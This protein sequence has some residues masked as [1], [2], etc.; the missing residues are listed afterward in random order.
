[1]IYS[2]IVIVVNDKNVRSPFLRIKRLLP[3]MRQL[4]WDI[5]A[6]ESSREK[7]SRTNF[8][9]TQVGWTVGHST[10]RDDDSIFNNVTRQNKH[11]TNSRNKECSGM[12]DWQN[13][14]Q[15]IFWS[16]DGQGK[17][18]VIDIILLPNKYLEIL[19]VYKIYL[20]N[21]IWTDAAYNKHFPFR[22]LCS[23][24]R[25]AEK[26]PHSK[27]YIWTMKVTHWP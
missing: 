6:T 8:F 12:L 9:V 24:N 23:F 20:Q 25:P 15:G 18:I 1:M 10:E 3:S 5:Y 22:Y 14:N 4:Q 16:P 2:Y 21:Y 11:L 27:V 19:H 13:N 17:I 7:Q 26:Q